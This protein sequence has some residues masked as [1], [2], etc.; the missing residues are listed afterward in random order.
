MGN[1]WRP[2][3]SGW[4]WNPQKDYI[5]KAIDQSLSRLKTDYIDLY[6]LHGGT[7]EDPIGDIIETFEKLKKAGKIR[8][9]GISSIRPN[10]IREYVTRS[11]MVSVMLQYS[12][13][14]RRPEEEMLSLLK[15]NNIGVLVRGAL[16]KGM[17]IS[18]TPAPF[19]NYTAEEV[20]H[21]VQILK[22]VSEPQFIPSDRAIHF[23]SDHPAVSSVVV[24]IRTAEQLTEALN[25][26]RSPAL[27]TVQLQTLQNALPPNIYA[28]HR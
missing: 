13:I 19:L 7:L 2:D 14:D 4:N 5:L 3:G 23:V 10:V 8:F 26:G 24:G 6:Q 28:E 15:N 16:A 20:S 17:L 21:A 27:N 25:A 1:Q 11:S 9:Y 12:L 18:K 22:S